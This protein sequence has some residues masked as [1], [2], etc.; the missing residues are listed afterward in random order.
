MDGDAPSTLHMA[1][2]THQLVWRSMA[3]ITDNSG[4]LDFQRE[5][6]CYRGIHSTRYIIHTRTHTV[7]SS[8]FQSIISPPFHLRPTP[9]CALAQLLLHQ[10]LTKLPQVPLQLFILCLLRLATGRAGARE[11]L[12]LPTIAMICPVSSSQ[13][14]FREPDVVEEE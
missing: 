1:R 9:Q 7:R 10:P 4:I 6:H 5:Y 13:F 3:R 12:G 2:A 8:P 11:V 14:D